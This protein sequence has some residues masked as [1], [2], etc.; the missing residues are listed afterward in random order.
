M[1]PL[2]EFIHEYQNIGWLLVLLVVLYLR[3]KE[4]WIDG[5]T[6]RALQERCQVVESKLETYRTKL[7]TQ[8]EKSAEQVATL[9]SILM[10]DRK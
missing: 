10:E 5:P 4:V 6:Y 3:N 1:Q 2:V 9:T 7:E 8:A